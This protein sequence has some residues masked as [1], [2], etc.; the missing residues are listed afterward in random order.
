MLN[1]ARIPMYTMLSMNKLMSAVMTNP[2][3]K[4]DSS[5]GK[6]V[7]TGEPVMATKPICVRLPVDVDQLVR[8]MPNRTEFLREVI[9]AA[10]RQQK[11]A[12]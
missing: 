2:K 7:E 12:S 11:K 6:F 1:R 3:Y 4:R 5:T 8:S 9:T 10:V